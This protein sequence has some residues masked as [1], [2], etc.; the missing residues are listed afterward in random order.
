MKRRRRRR[1]TRRRKRNDIGIYRK[2]E[3][4]HIGRRIQGELEGKMR[5]RCDHNS[6]YTY[7]KFSKNKLNNNCGL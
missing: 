1:R 7:I 6:L 3:W 5:D 4:I 2:L